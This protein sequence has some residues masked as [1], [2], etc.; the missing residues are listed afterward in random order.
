MAKLTTFQ[1][2]LLFVSYETADARR[3]EVLRLLREACLQKCFPKA[4][5]RLST[6]WWNRYFGLVP[7]ELRKEAC[8][9][10][11]NFLRYRR[12]E[13]LEGVGPTRLTR[14]QFSQ[15]AHVRRSKA[16]G[17]ERL[18]RK[19]LEHSTSSELF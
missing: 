16:Q 9:V 2:Y 15:L 12:Y 14:L 8:A 18:R 4:S 13:T 5:G 3:Q 11:R 7:V 6:A 1:E 19:H 17:R 10:W